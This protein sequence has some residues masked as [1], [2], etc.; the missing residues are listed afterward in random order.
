MTGPV[1]TSHARSH[2]S[3]AVGCVFSCLART[4]TVYM[5][6][7]LQWAN[8]LICERVFGFLAF[9]FQTYEGGYGQTPLGESLGGPA[10]CALAAMHL[11]PAEHECASRARLEPAEWR[12]TVRWLLHTQAEQAQPNVGGG[13][14]GRTNKVADACYGF[15]C[16]AALAV[17]SLPL[18][19]P[20]S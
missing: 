5:P 1:S 8:V 3:N 19:S 12:A 11:V 7:C 2:T 6:V 4:N 16:S 9:F 18:L 10:Y 17:R 14:A 13:F 20:P 15:W